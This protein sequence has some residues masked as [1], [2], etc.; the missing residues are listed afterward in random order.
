MSAFICYRKRPERKVVVSPVKSTPKNHPYPI[1]RST[2]TTPP[3]RLDRCLVRD[4]CD[5][6]R[7]VVLHADRPRLT[8]HRWRPL[9]GLGNA[10]LLGLLLLGEV[11][12]D[13]LEEVFPGAREADMLDADV[14]A[15]LDV[16]VAD[17][18]VAA[19]LL[20]R[21]VLRIDSRGQNVQNDTDGGLGHVVDDTSLAVVDLVGHTLLHGTCPSVSLCPVN[22]S[23]VFIP[24]RWQRHRRYHRRG[25]GGGRWTGRSCPSS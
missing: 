1:L 15:L 4:G 20:G 6:L 13:T 3:P 11:L 19:G 5:A 7:Y 16:S 18:S 8:G 2:N 10:L 25:T 14:D 17:L 21:A 24:Y 12:L 9:H 22:S 23:R